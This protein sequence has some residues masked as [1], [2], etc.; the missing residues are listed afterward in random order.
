MLEAERAAAYLVAITQRASDRDARHAFQSL[1]MGLA[2]PGASILDFGCGPGLDAQAYVARGFKVSAFDDDPATRELLRSRCRN[3]IDSGRL[4][5]HASDYQRFLSAAGS[6]GSADLVTANFAPFNL[7]AN[8]RELFVAFDRILGP[9]GKILAS[10]LSPYFIGDMRYGWWWRHLGYLVRRG[11]YAVPGERGPIIRRC[12]AV[13]AHAAA[14]QFT[15]R[16]LWPGT[17]SGALMLDHAHLWHQGGL[18]WLPMARCR[19]MFLLFAR[20]S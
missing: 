12:L 20:P 7:I 11:E 17:S 14:P 13:Y 5:L 4:Q 1:A 2:S 3:E 9:T 8:L 10:V 6:A 16:L 19:Y 18:A 15:L